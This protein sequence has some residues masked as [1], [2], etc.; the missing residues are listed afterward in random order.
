M[1]NLIR[2][3][4]YKLRKSRYFLGIIFL[5]VIFGMFLTEMWIEDREMNPTFND[6]IKNGAMSI[7]YAYERIS[8]GSFLFALFGEMFIVN[9][10]NNR[11][12]VRSF[13]YGFKRSKLILSKLIVYILFSLF[14]ELIYTIVLVTYVS[15]KYGFCGKIN[16]DFILYLFSVV[17]SLILFSIAIISIIAAVAI[18]TRS[19]FITLVLPIMIFGSYI[20]MYKNVGSHCFVLFS[21]MPW[22][23]PLVNFQYEADSIISIISLIVMLSM[24]IGGSLLFIRQKD[25]VN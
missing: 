17:V 18:I 1:I 5:A 11:N 7:Q 9:D 8:M 10:F 4:W 6:V 16:G 23:R 19:F 12:F 22:L 20:Y 25:I 15:N 24:T 13:S 21:C 3:E 2:G 14:L